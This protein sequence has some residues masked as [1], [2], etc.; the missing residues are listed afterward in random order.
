MTDGVRRLVEASEWMVE[1]VH[2]G[3]TR[4]IELRQ[5]LQTLSVSRSLDGDREGGFLLAFRAA[6]SPVGTARPELVLRALGQ[7]TGLSLKAVAV[8]RTHIHLK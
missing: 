4:S 6:V 7:A 8:S 3:R 5:Y 1:D 2:G